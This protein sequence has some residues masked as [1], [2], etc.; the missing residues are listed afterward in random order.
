MLLLF[1]F[2][3]IGFVETEKNDFNIHRHALFSKFEVPQLEK[4]NKINFDSHI[5]KQLVNTQFQKLECNAFVH[6]HIYSYQKQ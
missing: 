6:L 4:E 2:D 1:C 5:N 3:L